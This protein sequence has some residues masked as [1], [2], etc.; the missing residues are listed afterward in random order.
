MTKKA[1]KSF[2]QKKTKSGETEAAPVKNLLA[3]A[4]SCLIW[5]KDL[6]KFP[7]MKEHWWISDF[8]NLYQQKFCPGTENSSKSLT[9]I[10]IITFV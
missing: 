8:S 2:M 6:T 5:T 4:L 10:K 9:K 7:Q 1:L 3:S